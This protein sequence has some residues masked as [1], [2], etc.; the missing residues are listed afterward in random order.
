M[1]IR[2][3]YSQFPIG[4]DTYLKQQ[5]I[6]QYT[7][8][9][10]ATYSQMTP[11]SCKDMIIYQPKHEI[12]CF[13][14]KAFREQKQE[15]LPVTIDAGDTGKCMKHAAIKV[16]LI[17]CTV[18]VSH[19]MQNRANKTDNTTNPLSVVKLSANNHETMLTLTLHVVASNMFL[20]IICSDIAPL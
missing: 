2:N 3:N 12:T 5:H 16:K 11:I 4:S 7:L 10:Y 13:R 17:N 15:K 1:F 9:V 6:H 14:N 19:R 18:H 8:V 20:L